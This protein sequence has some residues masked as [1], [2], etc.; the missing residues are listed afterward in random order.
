MAVILAHLIQTASALP[1]DASAL[2]K[3]ISA[4]DNTITAREM[5]S[6]NWERWLPVF[7]FWV[8]VGVAVE[9]WVVAREHTHDRAASRRGTIRS[10]EMPSVPGLILELMSA[11]LVAVGVG[12][13]FWGGAVIAQINGDL[14]SMNGDLRNKSNQLVALLHVESQNA[15]KGAEEAKGRTVQLEKEAAAL[16]LENTRLEAIIQPRNFK[17]D[18]QRELSVTCGK[19]RDHGAE[20]SSYGMDTEAVGVSSQILAALHA[21]KI[22][23]AD[24]R[25]SKIETGPVEVGIHVRTK[26]PSELPFA[27]CVAEVLQKAGLDTKLN[28][29]EP[30]L[31]GAMMGGGGQA[32]VGNPPHITIFVGVKPLPLT[33]SKSSKL[34]K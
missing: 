34:N 30:P 18:R 12:L 20:L 33:T 11:V 25:Q 14:R 17:P 19:F 23:V 8:F 26:F 3:S 9:I 10:P 22:V 28:D 15:Q 27:S 29:P 2:E 21:A 5:S 6:G 4:L 32:F 24:N 16:Q 31:R 7:A 1:T 13:E